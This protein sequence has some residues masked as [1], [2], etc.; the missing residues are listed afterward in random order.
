MSLVWLPFALI[1]YAAFATSN[2]LD[3]IIV[4]KEIKHPAVVS[5]WVAS[6]G[7]FSLTLFGAGLLPIAGVQQFAPSLPPPAILLVALGAGVI[8]Q[9]ALLCMYSA[10]LKE[11]ATRVISTL[12]AATAVAALV[13]AYVLLGETLSTSAYT[14]SALLLAGA[15]L[16]SFHRKTALT[17]TFWFAV[18][19]GTLTALQTTMIKYAYD[20]FSFVGSFVYMN[21]G[22]VLYA[23]ALI[24]LVPTVRRSVRSSFHSDPDMERH[25]TPAP[26]LVWVMASSAIGAIGVVALNVSIK[27]GPVALVNGLRGIQYALI[28]LF[29]LFLSR[30]L[31][32]LLHEELSTHSIEQKLGAIALM[33]LGIMLLTIP[34][35]L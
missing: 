26:P 4:G 23:A 19:A 20:S 24:V 22:G 8:G 16:I 18:A 29:A 5:F 17:K 6:V 12:G 31:P 13:F 14:A 2:V 33:V 1:A 21:L 28:F 35:S 10:L 3:K 25:H 11:E 15:L 9:L 32:S 27:L 7:V 34:L 30:K